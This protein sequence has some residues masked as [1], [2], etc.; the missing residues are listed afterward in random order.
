M[1]S[2]TLTN[3]SV[4]DL[5]WLYAEGAGDVL[6]VIHVATM[7]TE[8]PRLVP[9]LEHIAEHRMVPVYDTYSDPV[10]GHQFRAVVLGSENH[11][12]ILAGFRECIDGWNTHAFRVADLIQPMRR[13]AESR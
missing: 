13:L 5:P 4:R 9:V 12:D 2:A 11:P 6:V 8:D 10:D 1:G 7:Q 3:L